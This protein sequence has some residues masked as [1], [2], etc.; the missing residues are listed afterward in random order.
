MNFHIYVPDFLFNLK[1]WNN[2]WLKTCENAFYIV[3]RTKKFKLN[4]EFLNPHSLCP[5]TILTTFLGLLFVFIKIIGG[6]FEILVNLKESNNQT[7][8]I[9]MVHAELWIGNSWNHEV[10]SSELKL[11]GSSNNEGSNFPCF[12]RHIF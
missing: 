5:Q 3:W 9:V 2:V 7:R 4:S 6:N 10:S 12:M 1:N 8:S 11:F